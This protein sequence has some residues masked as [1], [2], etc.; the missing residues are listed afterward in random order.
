MKKYPLASKEHG[1]S[2]AKKAPT[3]KS[4]A[5]AAVSGTKYVAKTVNAHRQNPGFKGKAS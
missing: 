1:T 5:R 4:G 3:V 2:P